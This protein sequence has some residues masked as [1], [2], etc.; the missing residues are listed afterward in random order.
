MESYAQVV[1]IAIIFFGIL[2][3]I[4]LV[5][6]YF[7][8]K[9]VYRSFDTISS[10]S[11]GITNNIKSFLKLSVV[12]VSY[13]WMVEH[14]AFYSIESTWLVYVLA[15]I[16]IDFVSYWSHRWNHE[17]NAL[18]NRHIIHHSSEEYNLAAALRQSISG[19]VEIYFFLYIPMALIGIPAKVIAVIAPLH[20]FAQ[21]WYH[22]KLIKRMGFLEH[23]IMTPSHHRVHHAINK[24]YIDKNYSAIF[25]FWDKWFGTFQEEQEDI[26]AVYGVKKAVETWN[27]VVINYLHFW[28]IIKD[29]WRTEKLWDKARVWFKPTGWRP[30]DVMEKYPV[31]YTVNANDQVKY[32][33]E[34]TVYLKIW[35]WMQLFIHLLLQFHLAANLGTFSY[36]NLL[37][38][39]LFLI[40]SVAAYTTLMDRHWLAVPIEAVKMIIGFAIIFSLGSWFQ[41]D[42]VVPSGTYLMA[43]YFVIS[44]GFA[45][46]YTLVQN[47]SF[48]VLG[49]RTV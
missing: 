27:P 44:M 30:A 40:L 14:W 9:K 42:A 11:S 25:I 33:T 47:E 37:I 26:P 24:E 17:I 35:S 15:F 22:T 1:T 20:L 21:F 46:Y 36:L 41:L 6:S 8:K 19:I 38:Y 5:A 3:A 45:L 10:L 49:K 4:E 28:Q 31:T 12:V 13:T 43:V 32:E 7:M 23:L 2:M 29:S 18:W 34:G 48:S 16:G 39:G